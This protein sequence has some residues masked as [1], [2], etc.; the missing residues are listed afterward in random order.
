[1]TTVSEVVEGYKDFL[2]V[3][4]PSHHVPFCNR[5]RNNPGSARAEAVTFSL[6]R[7]VVDEITIAEDVVEGGPDFLCSNG[8]A[9]FIVEV[10][11]LEGE[12]VAAQSGWPNAIPE[13][14]SGGSF[15]M[16]THTLRTK[17]SEKAS[18]LSGYEMARVLVITCEH[19]AA[20][21]LLGPLGAEMFLTSETKI[22]VPISTR[23]SI[24]EKVHL[25]T[26]LKDSVFFRFKNGL[27]EPCRQSISVIILL[28]VFGDDCLAVGIL[29]PN[30]KHVF[31][32]GLLPSVPFLRM[33]RWP[34]ENHSIET[35][36]VIHSPRPTEFYHRKVVLTERELRS[37]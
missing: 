2:M 4:Y 28:S 3:K 34:P 13:D 24:D 27:V 17:A 7:P 22:A 18:Q 10:T 8:D 9:K 21:V 35:E 31:S 19:I 6:L 30:P 16:I 11:S 29:H 32:I 12:A 23:E 37:T 25:T 20:D 5:L 15:G 26:D 14:G 1:M 36:W 33:K